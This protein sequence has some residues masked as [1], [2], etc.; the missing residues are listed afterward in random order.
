MKLASPVISTFLSNI[1]NNCIETGVFPECLKIA[2]V[3]PVY[4]SG[5]KS[6]VSNYRPIS[7]LN[8]FSKIFEK[9]LFSRLSD[10]CILRNIIS[11]NQFGFQTKSSTENAVIK[12]CNDVCNH[13][14]D[15]KIVCSIFLDLK[16]A[17]DTVNHKILMQKMYW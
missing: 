9:C 13:L 14:N 17:F 3:I 12:I 15:K 5:S 11:R 16:K 6:C 10:F 7:L 8:P 2:E 4:K 1:F